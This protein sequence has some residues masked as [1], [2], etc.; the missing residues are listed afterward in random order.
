MTRYIVNHFTHTDLDGVG[1]ACLTT[2]ITYNQKDVELDVKFCDY[3]DVNQQV[4]QLLDQLDEW[5]ASDDMDYY[6]DR[7]ILITDISV[8]EETAERL[9]SAANDKIVIMMLDHHQLSDKLRSYRWATVDDSGDNCGTSLVMNRFIGNQIN[10][11][12]GVID[13]VENVRLY[14]LWKF[15]PEERSKARS[16]NMLL[17]LFGKEHFLKLIAHELIEYPNTSID[18]DQGWIKNVLDCLYA[19]EEEYIRNKLKTAV[20][21]EYNGLH[22][23]YVFAEQHVSRIGNRMLKEFPDIDFAAIVQTPNRVSLRSREGGV[24]VGMD[25]AKQFGGGGHPCAAGYTMSTPIKFEMV[26]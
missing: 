5:K 22:G 13:F 14:D 12:Q 16:F 24:N 18:L 7:L 20:D 21:I 8:N 2:F 23:K 25:I 17:S 6:R 26:I 19:S 4:N 3:N 11:I 15:D 9:N 10:G 1:C